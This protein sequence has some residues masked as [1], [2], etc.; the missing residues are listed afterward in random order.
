MHD[1]QHGT[2][3][4]VLAALINAMQVVDKDLATARITILGPGAA[5][6]GVAKLLLEY[7]VGDIV[8]VDHDGIL[9][10]LRLELDAHKRELVAITNKER[11][12]GGVLEAVA[13]ADVVLGLSVGG[14]L[15]AEHIR[16]MAQRPVVFAM[17]NPEPEILPDAAKAAGAA[18]VAT[19]R[20]DFPN[21]VNNVLV[22][23]GVFRGALDH[24]VRTITTDMKLRAA[25]AL[26]GIIARPTAQKILPTVFD[27][28]VVKAVAAAIA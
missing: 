4:V 9:S 12:V 26:A 16:M 8:M 24:G 10:E 13:G 11:R 23:P 3:I 5:G 20:S 21:Q 28:R 22:F 15:Q 1:D 2:A 25:E 7:G 19:G 27:R 17:A 14:A 18:V 6:T